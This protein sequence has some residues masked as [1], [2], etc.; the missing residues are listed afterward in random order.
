MLLINRILWAGSH[1]PTVA[2]CTVPCPGLETSKQT[3]QSSWDADQSNQ[4]Q[5][6]TVCQIIENLWKK[7][8]SS[9]KLREKNYWTWQKTEVIKLA[10]ISLYYSSVFKELCA[11]FIYNK[12]M[13]KRM[14]YIYIKSKEV[15]ATI[16][17]EF[18]TVFSLPL[19]FSS[20]N[21]Y[22]KD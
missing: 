15:Q 10:Y 12:I 18:K 8:K 22:L 21:I 11:S 2:C 20:L 14:F 6:E 4:V 17:T 19:I 5:L 9:E 7:Q 1:C 13:Y 16:L 3:F